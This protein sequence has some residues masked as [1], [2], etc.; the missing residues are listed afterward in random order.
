[1]L[2]TCGTKQVLKALAEGRALRVFIARDADDRIRAKLEQA[3]R[4]AGIEPEYAESMALLGKQCGIAV[5]SA[6]AAEIKN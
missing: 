1:M 4:E 3:A 6:A 2:R 5:G